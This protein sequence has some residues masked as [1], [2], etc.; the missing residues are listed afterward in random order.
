MNSK[1]GGMEGKLTR[2]DEV[3]TRAV[4]RRQND[5]RVQDGSG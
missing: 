4:S 5:D 3:K 2:N 1:K